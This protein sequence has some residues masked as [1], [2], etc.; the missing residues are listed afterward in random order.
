MLKHPLQLPFIG[1]L[2]IFIALS[3]GWRRQPQM[4]LTAGEMHSD[5]LLPSDPV[6]RGPFR[7]PQR[8]WGFEGRAGEHLVL[9]VESF[10]LDS[11][12]ILADPSGRIIG[13]SDD[14][15]GFM[16]AMVE[17]TLPQTGRYAITVGGTDPEQ[18]G[19]YR[20]AA[21]HK[22]PVDRD[23]QR[24]LARGRRYTSRRGS[25]RAECLVN[26]AAAKRFR[27]MGDW[28]QASDC[29]Q[30]AAAAADRSGFVYG[31]WA[32]ALESGTL[33]ARTMDFG[34][35]MTDLRHALDVAR[36]L[37]AGTAAEAWTLAEIGDI[38]LYLDKAVQA[39]ACFRRALDAAEASGNPS[40][41]ARLSSSLVQSSLRAGPNADALARKA[42][43]LREAL[44]P[45]LRVDLGAAFAV[46]LSAAGDLPAALAVV[47]QTIPEARALG[48]R[49]AVAALLC[50]KSMI[51]FRLGRSAAMARSAAEAVEAAIPDDPD[52][53]RVGKALQIEADAAMVAGDNARAL[54]L[55]AKALQP[56]EVAWARES[57]SEVRVRLLSG[58]KAVCSQI[59]ATLSALNAR[60]PSE[61][62]A[63]EAF[64]YAERGRARNLLLDLGETASQTPVGADRSQLARESA[65]GRRILFFREGGEPTPAEAERI[66]AERTDVIAERI[67]TQ[68]KES[69]WLSGICVPAPVTAE[70]VRRELLRSHPRAAVL[71]YQLRPRDGVLIVITP[72]AARLFVLPGWKTIGDAVAAWTAQTAPGASV[73]DYSRVSRHLYDMLVAPCASMIRGK[74]LIIIPDYTLNSLPFEG[75]VVSAPENPA[76]FRELRYLVDEHP[77][78][79]A[80]SV[81]VLELLESRSRL[82][83]MS[84]P[85]EV[86][87]VGDPVSRIRP[88]NASSAATLSPAARGWTFSRL[89]GAG[90]EVTEIAQAAAQFRWKPDVRVGI[91]ASKR[92]MTE[93][94]A[95]LPY[96]IV[97][98]ATHA[99]ADQVEGGLSGVV[100]SAEQG[101][102]GGDV[103]LTA[104]EISHL[105][106]AADLVVLSGCSTGRGQVT[107]AEGVIG[108]GQAF[109]VAGARRVC[110]TL[111]NVADDAPRQLMPEFYRRYLA[112]DSEPAEALRGAKLA[113]IRAGAPPS[114]WAPMVL[115][116]APDEVR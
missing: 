82:R 67:R 69:R 90:A 31:K 50:S 70:L 39:H 91:D 44:D 87:L 29:L 20:L 65:I 76:S 45:A 107:N 41:L 4:S 54:E 60:Q 59:I 100:L 58:I 73:R 96:R 89:S 74:D 63:L 16:N 93:D 92:S 12:L 71:S 35:A 99:L 48:Y 40:A 88:T 109:L 104:E 14:S 22:N 17:V 26:V 53:M 28:R 98:I 66:E 3:L 7:G 10:E 108:L 1:L 94:G 113:L 68:E 33:A 27:E 42:H 110:T 77:V 37:P 15:G 64:D 8:E 51:E 5:V 36:R 6:K 13:Q 81:S 106:L 83:S 62:Y 23:V 116:G 112:R 43:D 56:M 47:G 79:Y 72:E 38:F 84:N 18:Y 101:D 105:K 86:L 11:F 61:R 46:S 2:A 80:P 111:W 114:V 32:A 19:A 115:V 103:F 25:Q 102:T 75:L 55:C 9:T 57:V 21:F 85:N 30:T 95:L 24:Y 52:P 49:D 34:R 78:T 97:H